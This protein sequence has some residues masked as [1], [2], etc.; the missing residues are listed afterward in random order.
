MSS[1]PRRP[2]LS[3]KSTTTALWNPLTPP[4]PSHMI[5]K[6]RFSVDNDSSG[7][8]L[9][10]GIQYSD[11]GISWDTAT[12]AAGPS[13][14]SFTSASGLTH[15]NAIFTCPDHFSTPTERLFARFGVWVKNVTGTAAR[16]GT[17][18][19]TV[20]VLPKVAGTKMAGPMVTP[21]SGTT[22]TWLF[23]PMLEM[24]AT[25]VDVA[26][27]SWEMEANTGAAE[28]RPGFQ[29]SDD[30]VTWSSASTL[31]AT[32]RTSGGITYGTSWSSPAVNTRRFVRFGILT[33]NN[34]G[35]EQEGCVST[36]RLDFRS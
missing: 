15:W 24:P 4:I 14:P 26:R 1:S 36:L 35:S 7:L 31:G 5:E 12:E 34:S 30:G 23:T 28:T 21:S 27:L 16:A 17:V 29:T 6:V 13:S 25:R 9:L 22:T 20:D 10:P 2:I 32:T 18:K 8:L 3:G 33:K 11:D 19:L